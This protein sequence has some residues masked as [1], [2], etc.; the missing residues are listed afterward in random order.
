M[1]KGCYVE[2]IKRFKE[3]SKIT[4]YYLPHRHEIISDE[5]QSLFD[6]RF[7]LIENKTPIEIFFLEKNIYPYHIVSFT[8]SALFNLSRIYKTQAII[9]ALTIHPD[10]IKDSKY[11]DFIQECYKMFKEYQ[12][13]CINILS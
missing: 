8:S 5:L 1:K 9:S 12:I 4:I 2:Y 10:D 7:I 13:Q 11:Y 3:Y 6:E